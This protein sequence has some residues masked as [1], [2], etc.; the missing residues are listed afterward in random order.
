MKY[1]YKFN[2]NSS[3]RHC[4]KQIRERP[5]CFEESLPSMRGKHLL[6]DRRGF[7]RLVISNNTIMAIMINKFKTALLCESCCMKIEIPKAL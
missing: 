2:S 6:D 7:P 5:S 4:K 3:R 1:K